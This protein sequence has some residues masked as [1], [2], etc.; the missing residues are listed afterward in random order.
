MTPYLNWDIFPALQPHKTSI[1]TH[2]IS[3]ALNFL[4]IKSFQ[5]EFYQFSL[6]E[7]L[8]SSSYFKNVSLYYLIVLG[9][10][11][12]FIYWVIIAQISNFL[13]FESVLCVKLWSTDMP[14]LLLKRFSSFSVGYWSALLHV[15]C[16]RTLILAWVSYPHRC[17]NVW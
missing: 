11:H 3:R 17:C 9:N 12:L 14:V 8:K 10:C 7:L 1:P 15:S 13:S 5:I 6:S 2:F 16:L 4:H